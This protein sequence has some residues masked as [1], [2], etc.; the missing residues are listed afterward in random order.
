M[1]RRDE[2]RRENRDRLVASSSVARPMRG[3]LSRSLR[4]LCPACL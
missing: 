3:R 4:R 1:K 2:M